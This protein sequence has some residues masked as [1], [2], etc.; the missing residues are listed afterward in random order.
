MS[1]A[2]ELAFRHHPAGAL[3]TFRGAAGI[4]SARARGH[5]SQYQPLG[6]GERSRLRNTTN[7]EGAGYFLESMQSMKV[8]ARF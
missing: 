2:A 8:C 4:G 3:S 5:A 1:C 7:G 6:S